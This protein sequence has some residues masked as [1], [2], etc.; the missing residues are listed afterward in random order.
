MSMFDDGF[1]AEDAFTIGGAMGFAEESMQAEEEGLHDDP[2]LPKESTDTKD[3][4]LRI[5]KNT[6]PTLFEYIVKLVMDHKRKWRRQMA[7]AHSK[8]TESELKAMAETEKLL[9]EN[10]A[11]D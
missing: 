11:A 6:N 10:D 1:D 7:L 8:E 9:E 2:E 5:F 3:V 4:N